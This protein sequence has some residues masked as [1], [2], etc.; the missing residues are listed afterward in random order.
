MSNL[1]VAFG[2]GDSIFYGAQDNQSNQYA[3]GIFGRALL[4]NGTPTQFRAGF[5]ACVSGTSQSNYNSNSKIRYWEFCADIVA[6][7]EATND[8]QSTGTLITAAA[9]ITLKRTGWTNSKS[10]NANVKLITCLCGCRTTSTDSFVTEANQTAAGTGWDIAGNVLTYNTSLLA[11]VG[12][13][14]DAIIRRDTERGTLGNP[15]LWK[16][17]PAIT[18]DGL[19]P[20]ATP[21]AAAGLELATKMASFDPVNGA[22]NGMQSLPTLFF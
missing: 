17:P 13:N 22:P 3:F 16:A 5:N 8:F 15:T 18:P 4:G 11:E 19:H 14:V 21:T 9:C 6:D 2:H 20:N 12:A 10:I 7:N 1:L